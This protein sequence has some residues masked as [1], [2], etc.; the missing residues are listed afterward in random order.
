MT[1]LDVSARALATKLL[2]KFGKVITLQSV[3]EG[4]YDPLTGD[5]A[6]NTVTTSTP[7]AVISDYKGIALMSGVI[8]YGDRKVTIAALNSVLPQ[9]ADTVTIDSEVYK[10]LSV[11]NVWS[12]DLSALY[13]LQVRK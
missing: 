8:Q 1:A 7:F 13:E 9:P 6:A 3:V 11:R 10:V 12:G 5:M 4:A 2:N